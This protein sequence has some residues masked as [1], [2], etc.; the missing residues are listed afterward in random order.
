MQ[1]L[2]LKQ[3]PSA[4]SIAGSAPFPLLSHEGVRAYRRALFRSDVLDRCASSPFPATLVLR[5]AGKQSRFIR[6]FWE[7]PETR[8]IVSE[9]AGVP[10]EVVMPAEIGHTNIQVEGVVMSLEHFYVIP[11]ECYIKW[12]QSGD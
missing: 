6:D 3:A 12:Y 11:E 9:V 2:S 5:D 10:L 7:H 8:R 1:E 4:S